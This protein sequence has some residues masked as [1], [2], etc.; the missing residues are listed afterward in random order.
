MIRRLSVCLLAT[1]AFAASAVSTGAQGSLRAGVL[2][3]YGRGGMTFVVGSVHEFD[4]TFRPDGGFPGPES[5][6]GVVR[7]VGLDL[8][9]TDS[10]SVGWVV[11]APTNRIGRGELAGTYVGAAANAS[12]GVGVGGNALV[13]GS[14]NTFALQPVSLQGQTGL[15]VA[16]G[17]A[18][19]ELY[20][21]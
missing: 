12:V 14:N 3:C 21:R 1:A 2:E 20:G 7:R 9:F 17:I 19:L 8:G 11:L 4:C 10:V 13:G 6:R 18:Q 16:A 15:N 5:Y